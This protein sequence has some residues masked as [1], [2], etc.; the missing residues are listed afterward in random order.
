MGVLPVVMSASSAAYSISDSGRRGTPAGIAKIKLDVDAERPLGC[1]ASHRVADGGAHVAALG[2]VPGAAEATRWS[3]SG[4]AP[5][6]SP[7][8]RPATDL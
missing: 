8:A 2:D 3:S 5:A 6:M 1:L 7:T 4:P